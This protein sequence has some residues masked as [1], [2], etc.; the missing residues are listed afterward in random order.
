MVLLTQ[1]L[2]KKINNNYILNNINL[3]VNKG[4]IYGFIGANGAGKSTFMSIITSLM[5]KNSGEITLFGNNDYKKELKRVGTM[6]EYPALYKGFTVKDNIDIQRIY[7]GIKNKDETLDCLNMVGLLGVKDKKVNNISMGMK[8]KLMLAITLLGSPEL[9]ILDE[10]MNGLDPI[11]M[12]SMRELLVKLNKE[13]GVTIFLSSHILGELTKLCTRFGFI[14]NGKLIKEVSKDEIFDSKYNGIEISV[15]DN[16]KCIEIMKRE[17]KIEKLNV[18]AEGNIQVFDKID[19][20]K[21]FKVL[22]DNDIKILKFSNIENDIENYLINL[23]GG[24]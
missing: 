11:A 2:T 20:N 5:Q 17:L 21:L 24:E 16:F 1:N 18:T 4:D 14:K 19:E 12:K 22:L 7:L 10:P 3:K 15:G 6:I 13:N 8:Q 23:I 9:L